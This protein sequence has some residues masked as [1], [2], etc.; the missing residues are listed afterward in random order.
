MKAFF[1]GTSGRLI[2]TSID[3]TGESEA[4]PQVAEFDRA[5]NET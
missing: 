5:H 4:L 1:V 3:G 2:V